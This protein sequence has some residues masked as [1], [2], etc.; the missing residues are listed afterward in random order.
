MAHELSAQINPP[1]VIYGNYVDDRQHGTRGFSTFQVGIHNL[2][3]VIAGSG[4]RVTSM[5][6]KCTNA[7]GTI[8]TQ[9]VP[10]SQIIITSET[11][12]KIYYYAR[13]VVQFSLPSSGH[14]NCVAR[15]ILASNMTTT[16]SLGDVYVV[17]PTW[18]KAIIV[19]DAPPAI[20][21]NGT[22]AID[23]I[24]VYRWDTDNNDWSATYDTYTSPVEVQYA[25]ETAWRFR[26]VFNE[27]QVSRTDEELTRYGDVK[28]E[29]AYKHYDSYEKEWRTAFFST[30]RNQNYSNGIYNVMFV[31][32]VEGSPNYSSRA[33]W[34]AINDPLYFPD[35]N[36]V[37]VGSND[38]AIVGLTKVGD[39]LSAI[40]QS[41]ATDTAIY[42]LYPTS[43][44][45]ET[46]FA[47]KQG[48]Q[49]VGALARYAFNILGSETLFLSPNGVMAIVPTQ[50]EE[51]KVQNRSYFIDKKLLAEPNIAQAYS[52]VFDG[53]Y[54]LAVPNG[55]G[56][57]YVLDGNQRNSWGNDKTNLVYECYYLEG[58][59]AK[60]FAKQNGKLLFS[61]GANLCRFTDGYTDE[62][63]GQE[64]PVFARWSTLFDDDGAL[65]YYKTMQKKGNLIS[66]LPLGN[67]V[68][69][70]EVTLTQEE[71]EADPT[72]YFVYEEGKY[73]RCG[74]GAEYDAT[75]TYYIENET[76]TKVYVR[77]D[78]DERT[79]IEKKFAL[80]SDIPSELFVEKKFKKYKRLQFIIENDADE[81]FGVDK[82]IKNYTVGNYAKK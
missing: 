14:W 77:K 15:F 82:I 65:N 29:L 26:F 34:S 9:D 6:I 48:V 67:Q 44:E 38:T 52:F 72:Q 49:G 80:L 75:E 53:K 73:T 35:T 3:N 45:E 39:Y 7:D 61:D 25:T 78:G 23:Y 30:T 20:L 47:V 37:E 42:L 66:V 27:T 36:Y 1:S 51:H 70:I 10:S 76:H 17:D 59:P 11:A 71:F 46:T 54:F 19:N 43:F 2:K 64:I 58:V 18:G 33:W 8:Y 41:K 60:C 68:P 32:G 22:A 12:K 28:L 55:E 63:M 21:S 62:I 4:Y 13:I 24:K 57:V 79:E 16:I 74:T 81:D 50:D 40:K 69:Y 5:S 56:S 31:S